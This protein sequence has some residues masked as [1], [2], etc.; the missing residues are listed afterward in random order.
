VAE[1][2]PL[3]ARF[4]GSSTATTQVPMVLLHGFTQ[5]SSSWG[6]LIPFLGDGLLVL[7]DAPGHGASSRV[8]T[9][10]WGTA[11]LLAEL[12]QAASPTVAPNQCPGGLVWVGYSMGA[13]TALHVALAYPELVGRLVLVSGAPG[14]ED[15]GQR[16]ERRAADDVLARRAEAEGVEGF[17]RWWVSQPIFATLP[18]RAADMAGR[19]ANTGAGLASSLRLTG[20]GAQEPLWDRLA[21]L[22]RRSLPVLVVAGSLDTKYCDLAAR[23]AMEIGPSATVMVVDDAGHACHLEKPTVVGPAIARFAGRGE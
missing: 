5:T 7:P 11:Q 10:L 4:I 18:A 19:L 8:R 23:M 12:A 6:A 2:T 16:Q 14:I 13:R 3:S 17:V 22:G 1:Y 15:A 9:D 20:T 21:E